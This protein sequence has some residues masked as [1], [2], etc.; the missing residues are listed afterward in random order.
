[1]DTH[2]STPYSVLLLVKITRIRMAHGLCK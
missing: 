1:M 2:A